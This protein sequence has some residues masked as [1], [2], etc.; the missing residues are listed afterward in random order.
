GA[1]AAGYNNDLIIG[2]TSTSGNDVLF[3]LGSF[4]SLF[5][6]KTWNLSSLLSGYDLTTVHWGVVGNTS[7]SGVNRVIYTTFNATPAT[8]GAGTGSSVNT[9]DGAL[10]SSFVTAGAGNS[11]TISSTQDNSWNHQTLNPTLPTQYKNAYEDPNM[12]GLGQI[13]FWTIK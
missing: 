2:F 3:D 11:A 5:D 10:Y 13:N 1:Q 6:G 7:A 8:A 9:A 4:G 12:V